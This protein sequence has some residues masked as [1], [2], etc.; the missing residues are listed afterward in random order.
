MANYGTDI[1]NL[2]LPKLKANLALE[3]EILAVLES[4]LITT[5]VNL[6]IN[7]TKFQIQHLEERIKSFEKKLK[8]E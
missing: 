4:Q 1:E 5:D 8:N 2:I 7:Y 6:S 3:K